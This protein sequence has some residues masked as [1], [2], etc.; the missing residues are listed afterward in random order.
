MKRRL[1]MHC[2]LYK[3]CLQLPRALMKPSAFA[4]HLHFLDLINGS[5]DD[6][7]T[8]DSRQVAGLTFSYVRR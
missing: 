6:I 5:N 3:R 1:N 7:L 4:S 8:I 2:V